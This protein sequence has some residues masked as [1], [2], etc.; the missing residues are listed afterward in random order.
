MADD[1]RVPSY[2]GNQNIESK[3]SIELLDENGNLVAE[4]AGKATNRSI[5]LVRNGSYQA[6]WKLDLDT[7]EKYARKTQVNTG[8]ILAIGKHQARIK[9]QGVPIFSGQISFY[10]TELSDKKEI[11]IKVLGWLDLL[12]DRYTSIERVFTA[13]DAGSIAWTLIDE[14]QSFANGSFGITQGTIQTSVPR[15]RTYE[16]KNIKEAIIQLS[17]VYNGFDFEFGW[18]KRFSVFYPSMG[19][20][21][22]TIEFRYPG[23][24]KT[25]KVTTDGTQLLNYAVVRGQGLGEGQLIDIRQDAASQINYKLRQAIKDYS[26][27]PDITILQALGDEDVRVMKD[28]L[29]IIE[30]TIDGNRQPLGSFWVGDKV[31]VV[32]EGIVLY[33]H[34]NSYYRI[35]EINVS[36][37]EMDNEDITLKLTLP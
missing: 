18:D 28:P 11:T 26:E 23:N 34:I 19:I 7:L 20:Q 5:S 2:T 9:R 3:Y 29:E 24:V 32:M 37:D 8:S 15:N 17:E 33:E 13:E 10:E 21:R 22:D 27:I 6:E 30:L 1:I 4:L 36:I 12:K 25:A 35:D 14:S 16:W 31:K